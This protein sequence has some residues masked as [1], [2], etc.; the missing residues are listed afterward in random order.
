MIYYLKTNN[1]D[2]LYNQKVIN[3]NNVFDDHFL[4]AR[5]LYLYCFNALPS[6]NYI[7]RIDGEKAFSAFRKEFAGK[8]KATHQYR[9][10]Q[11]KKKVYRFDRTLLILDN[12]S[13]VEFDDNYC[14]IYHNGNDQVFVQ[15][16][17]DLVYRFKERQRRQP[18]EINLVVQT[19]HSLELRGMEI[20]RTKLDLGLFY[21]D[22]FKETDELIQKRLRQKN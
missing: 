14:E 11:S 19:R 3:T 21:E 16:V 9:W 20:K 4:D 8:I 10:Y 18:L 15:R 7:G 12:E 2:N 1:M 22:D 5:M 17:T 13:L 6:L